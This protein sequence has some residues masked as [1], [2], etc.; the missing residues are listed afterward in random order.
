MCGL[1][2]ILR[3]DGCP[4][5]AK[6]IAG[7]RDMLSHRGPNDAGLFVEGSIGLGHQRL[8]IIDLSAA[9]RSR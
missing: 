8:S 1:V 6:T 5:S 3:L 2:G 7:M 4:V 9:A